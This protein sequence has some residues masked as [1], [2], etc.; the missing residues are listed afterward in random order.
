MW[1]QDSF[2]WKS[3][4]LVIPERAVLPKPVQ[5][6]HPP[7]WQT[8]TSPSRSRWRASWRWR[9]R[10]RCSRHREPALFAEYRK[11]RHAPAGAFVNE[12]ISCSRSCTAPDAQVAIASRAAESALWFLNAAPNVFQVPRK[13]DRR[14]PRRSQSSDP[15]VSQSVAARFRGDLTTAIR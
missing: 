1:M 15:R 8:R 3:D 5:V 13:S 4:L 9:A 6:P 7:L 12:Q 10:R 14:D 11:A 2:S